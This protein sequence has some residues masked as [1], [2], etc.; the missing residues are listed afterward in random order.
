MLLHISKAFDKVRHHGPLYKLKRNG[1]NSDLFKLIESFLSDRYQRV[2]L[3]GQNLQVEKNYDWGSSRVCFFL[4]YISDLP[5]E[6]CCS[7]KL[8]A[9]DKS[10]FSVVKNVNETAKKLNKDLENISKWAHQWKMSFNP[11]PTKMEK[12]ALF[13]RKNLKV[14]HPNLT[15]IG[16]GVHSSPFEKHLGLVLNSKFKF[17]HE[18]NR[19][20]FYGK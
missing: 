19:K 9:D 4:I 14:I 6:L 8:F 12:E 11:D 20:N 10:L 1:I 3:N 15:F 2:A 18:F 5:S 13:S 16:K 7:P 17:R